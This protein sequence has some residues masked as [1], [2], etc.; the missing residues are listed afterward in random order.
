[1][2]AP[3]P[4]LVES[5]RL[6]YLISI[7]EAPHPDGARPLLVFLHGYGEGAPMPIRDALTQHGPLAPTASPLARAELIVV[8][9]QLPVRGDLWVHQAGTVAG[10]VREAHAAHGADPARTY[11]TGFSFGGNGVF[12]VGLAT[13]QLWAALWAV[14]PTRV[15]DKVIRAPVWLSSGDRSR[16]REHNFIEHLVLEPMREGVPG[17]RVFEDCGQDH[18]G[19][20]RLAY[21]DDEIYRWL[22]S[23]RL[24]AGH[25]RS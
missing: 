4:R 3:E 11:L 22:L 16:R 2:T 23:K 14:D 21:A 19:T 20:A 1:M 17:D 9:P 24:S 5:G 18:V 25:G 15:P 13:P 12:D 7:P 6:P 10:I 8:A